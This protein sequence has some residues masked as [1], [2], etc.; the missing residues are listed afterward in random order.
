MSNTQ[1]AQVSWEMLNNVESINAVDDIYKYDG[2]QQQDI[3]AAKPWEK[4]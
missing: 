4:E 1:M 3:L 2:R